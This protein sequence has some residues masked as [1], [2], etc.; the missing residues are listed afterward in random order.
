MSN[1]YYRFLNPIPRHT[2]ARAE[3]LNNEYLAIEAG[4]DLLPGSDTFASR[5]TD[6]GVATGV[7]NSYSVN[8]TPPPTAYV[9]GFAFRVKI[10]P[11]A[12]NTGPSV[13]NVNGLGA[14]AILRTNGA[15]VEAGDLLAGATYLLSDD[16]T[17]GLRIIG[18]L[19]ATAGLDTVPPHTHVVADI[20]D[21]AG[22]IGVPFL[23]HELVG[24]AG[25]GTTDES[26]ALNASFL[27]QSALGGAV[28]YLES[29]SGFY[30][31][32]SRVRI[33]SNIR[34]FFGSK[35][36]IR[37]GK[38][39]R[40]VLQGDLDEEPESDKPFLTADVEVGATE[41]TLNTL[42]GLAA[43]DRIIIR[44]LMDG[45]LN[46]QERQE[47]SIASVAGLTITITDPTEFAF[48]AV[49]PPGD[50]EARFGVPNRTRIAEKVVAEL[51]D[52]PEVGDFTVLAN[53]AKLGPFAVGDTV[54]VTDGKKSR[55][56]AGTSNNRIN[57]ELANILAID[58]DTG[59]VTFDH[60]I[61]NNITMAFDARIERINPCRNAW[62]IGARIETVQDADA[63]PAP[64][65]HAVEISRGYNCLVADCELLDETTF[66]TRGQGFRVF[67]SYQSSRVRCRV[68]RRKF[69]G[70]GDGYA[71]GDFYS[72]ATVDLDCIASGGRHHDL[73]QGANAFLSRG[74]VSIDCGQSDIDCHGLN[75]R[76]GLFTNFQILGGPTIASGV[77]TKA[78]VKLGNPTHVAGCRN[79]TVR[80]G[81][82]TGF[83]AT[84]GTSARAIQPLPGATE[85]DIQDI[86]VNGA[87]FG[88]YFRQNEAFPEVL[89]SGIR[90]TNITLF[91]IT[92]RAIDMRAD[93]I[94]SGT[95]S[96]VNLRL[97]H[98]TV[99]KAR[100]VAKLHDIDGVVVDHLDS[101]E[102]RGAGTQNFSLELRRSSNVIVVFTRVQGLN[103]GITVRDCPDHVLS[104]NLIGPILDTPHIEDDS[105]NNDA[106][107]LNNSYIGAP[108]FI[109]NSTII[110]YDV[111]RYPLAEEVGDGRDVFAVDSGAAD[112]YVLAS[113]F[114]ASAY[115]AGLT[116]R[117]KATNANT[118]ASTVNVDGLGLKS[119]KTTSGDD[120]SAGQIPLNGV[121]Q[122]VY[123]GTDFQLTGV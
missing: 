18:G 111:Q 33:R 24:L 58:T 110:H 80:G 119:I 79:I 61:Q 90:L 103:R 1:P 49:Y 66:G 45:D 26:S 5:T 17:S 38:L 78:A 76:N 84:S 72:T 112:A 118:G 64:R 86:E 40:L 91:D 102:P 73:R 105:G 46:P 31:I 39:G 121:V 35:T 75:E 8:L 48:K 74:L 77:T 41:L 34:V 98:L 115:T 25:D 6:F 27:A 106:M 29:P 14:R 20:I 100:D 68:G 19:M 11:L 44:G 30:R 62:L 101:A 94:E 60:G 32:D 54:I 85:C 9:V 117:F 22:Q 2:V 123:D 81:R 88:V 104:H 92:N 59:A 96:L 15:P 7:P 21:F 63:A 82:V 83:F 114:P 28:Y 70:S 71:F 113:V 67:E 52:D 69:T 50:Y 93:E 12:T 57:V 4:F 13:I 109:K 55:D 51:V 23:T 87:E 122:I 56:I 42:S 116:R 53:A 47:T 99:R 97:R 120:P 10:P 3:A 43:G 108:T 89:A 37:R 16:G 65:V 36:I 107:W 95:R